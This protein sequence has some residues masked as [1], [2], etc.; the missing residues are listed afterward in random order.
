MV[1]EQKEVDLGDE[2]KAR[3]FRVKMEE[4]PEGFKCYYTYVDYYNDLN[5][6]IHMMFKA[7]D[8]RSFEDVYMSYKGIYD[9]GAPV[10]TVTYPCEDNPNWNEETK[11]YYDALKEQT[12]V[13]W[14]V[15]VPKIEQNGWTISIPQMQKQLEY[16]FAVISQYVHFNNDFPS[17]FAK[18]VN[19]DGH[20]LQISYQYT[21]NNNTDLTEY[22]P[23]LDIVRGKQDAILEK[24]AEGVAG[25][26][27]P[28]FFRLNNE[29][30]TDWTSYCGVAN[31]C[32]PE[33]F[34]DSWVRLYD[35][36]TEKGANQYAMW[37]FNGTA[38]SFP[39]MNWANYRCYMP[40]A[41][42][43]DLIGLTAYNGTSMA[44][45]EEGEGTWQTFKQLYDDVCTS[46]DKNYSGHFADWPWIISEFGCDD[47]GEARATWITEMFDCFA[48]G[49][50]PNIKV[51]IWFSANDYD[52]ET[53]EV[54]NHYN[55]E[56]DTEALK[57]FRD[58]L[59]DTQPVE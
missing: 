9:K 48:A 56:G 51:A 39:P 18:K 3:V 41:K 29:M 37:I 35:I 32:D 8:D 31:M 10:E 6:S 21:T 50:Y 34:V 24:F 15:F 11:A 43:I 13:D 20:M 44:E 25:Y 2:W 59:A 14:G 55:L 17:D 38:G 30:N 16:D 46:P 47:E 4:C 19:D 57:A 54:T 36:F 52:A 1:D 49:D 40:D 26:G 45:Q 22:S 28:L 5:D 53:G 58:G 23:L 27:H 42:Y 12:H 7:V 33:L